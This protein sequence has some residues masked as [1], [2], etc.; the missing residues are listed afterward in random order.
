MTSRDHHTTIRERPNR[1]RRRHFRRK[2]HQSAAAAQRRKQVDCV[3]I[4]D[5]ELRG[6]VGAFPGR[7]E[8]WSFD[9][10]AEHARDALPDR[11]IDRF[12]RARN[13]LEIVTEESG[14]VSRG[15]AAPM[16]LSYR[17]YAGH[18]RVVVEENPAAAVHLQVEEAR[19]EVTLQLLA[20]E[21]VRAFARR[22][23]IEDK[24]AL[25]DHAAILPKPVRGQNARRME[26][27]R[28]HRVSIRYNRIPR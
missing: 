5:P 19:D 4:E 25:E 14:Q 3:R 7:G 12:D 16:R 28:A 1:A 21:I 11:R 2:R 24:A 22:E 23:H 17:R 26:C 27:N 15:S 8:E 18:R 6:I 10:N 9:V 13:D 20:R